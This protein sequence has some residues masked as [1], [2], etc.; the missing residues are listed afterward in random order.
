MPVVNLQHDNR[1]GD[2]GQ[3]LG[4]I[5]GQIVDA[6]RKKQMAAD[7][8]QTLQDPNIAEAKK[9]VKILE[10]HGNE[11][12]EL[13]K[14]QIATQAL[15]T[16]MK[17]AEAQTRLTDTQNQLASEKLKNSPAEFAANLALTRQTARNIGSQASA[18][19]T[20]LPGQVV[21]QGATTANVASQTK[22]RDT[23]L[24]GEVAQQGATTAGTVIKT[25]GQSIANELAEISL[26][27]IK[28]SMNDE[29]LSSNL[30]GLIKKFG[31]EPNSSLGQIAKAKF[32][33]EKDPL[34]K[35]SAFADVFKGV[36]EADARTQVP[37]DVRKTVGQSSESAV[38]MDKFVD[39]FNSGGAQKIG[40]IGGATVQ[41]F[42]EKYGFPTGDP[43]L[44]KMMNSSIQSA[45]S[46][47]TQGGGFYSQGRFALGKDVTPG[48]RET[49]LH[50]AV[51]MDEVVSRQIANLEGQK[52]EAPMQARPGYDTQIAKWRAIEKKID[53][54]SYD[55]DPQGKGKTVVFFGGKEVDAKSFKPKNT[56][57]D[58]GSKTKTNSTIS[59]TDLRADA[60][61][62][63]VAP[64]LR[65]KAI[66]EYYRTH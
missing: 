57:L 47:A 53:F 35:A 61:R 39:A 64:E 20:L 21:E 30:D 32:A 65:L 9:G 59:A 28:G 25:S 34:K 58:T 11:G 3:G 51:A 40:T 49:P 19:D 4:V 16:K 55:F 36:A 46:I 48:I 17:E 43:E 60:E 56:M 1:W 38:S 12:Y 13:Y 10:Q 52:S 66:Q 22:A 18:R 26:K 44:L 23:L 2:I 8:A 6:V 14:Q 31:Y 15:Q 27:S 7:V 50:A 41:A 29:D 24:P 62:I 54:K 33:A 63:G 45:A 5:G 37:A 42:F